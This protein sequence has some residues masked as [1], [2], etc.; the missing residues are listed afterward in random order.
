MQG[1]DPLLTINFRVY[2]IGLH[3]PNLTL[4]NWKTY[5]RVLH[6]QKTETKLHIAHL[7]PR[8]NVE[9]ERGRTT[10]RSARRR[11]AFLGKGSTEG[12]WRRSYG[13]RSAS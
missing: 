1:L 12:D 2:H 8:R 11:M 5:K 4:L 10:L 7:L 6:T 9:Q 3:E 13:Q